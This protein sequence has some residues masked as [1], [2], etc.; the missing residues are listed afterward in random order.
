VRERGLAA[1]NAPRGLCGCLERPA[2]QTCCCLS[3]CFIYCFYLHF[4]LYPHQNQAC[5]WQQIQN[6]A[7]PPN[8]GSTPRYCRR[9][10]ALI[11]EPLATIPVFG[12]PALEAWRN[13]QW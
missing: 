1:P 13:L 4:L 8:L 3:L 12:S 7:P 10:A 2:P 9:P 6:T 5:T 11:P